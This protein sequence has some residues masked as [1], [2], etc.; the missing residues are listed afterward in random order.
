MQT[1]LP[2]ARKWS[3][4]Q[5]RRVH[6]SQFIYHPS[7]VTSSYRTVVFQLLFSLHISLFYRSK[8]SS[9]QG[10]YLTGMITYA[11]D[12]F[13]KKVDVY[14]FK[15]IPHDPA[16]KFNNKTDKEKTKM[17]E[18]TE[19]LRDLKTSTLS[20]LGNCFEI[21]NIRSTSDTI[22]FLADVLEQANTLYD[23]LKT[24]N[25]DHL[26]VH[27]AMMQCLD[28]LETK[29]QLPLFTDSELQKQNRATLTRITEIAELVISSVDTEKLL[30]FLAIKSDQRQDAAK[31]K[32]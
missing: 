10:Q 8:I 11:K 31:L 3:Q 32:R 15:F 21:T 5:E 20:K 4:L 19:A 22:C 30:S 13:G 17:E 24:A 23:E 27:S 28:A 2:K 18:Y 26:A 12:E 9:L 16:K 7:S 25:P 29:S 6:P 1:P 14:P